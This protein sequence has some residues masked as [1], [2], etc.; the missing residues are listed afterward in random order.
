MQEQNTEFRGGQR[1]QLPTS[2]DVNSRLPLLTIA[3]P[4]WNREGFLKQNLEQLQ[5]ELATVDRDLVE[6]IVSDNCSPD[7]TQQVAQKFAQHGV[8]NRYV[9]NTANLG[10]ALNFAQCF[11]FA[12][13]RYLLLLGD[14]DLLFDGALSALLE[15]LRNGEFGVV[16]L[17]AY[18]FD[19]DFRLE[20]P[21][22]GGSAEEF[23]DANKF[24]LSVN[25]RFTLTSVCVINKSLIPNVDSKQF[26]DTNLATFHLVLRASLAAKRNL[27]LGAYMLACKRQ[28]SFSYDWAQVFVDEFWRIVDAHVVHG[29]TADCIRRI[30]Q[31]RLLSYY[32]FYAL[33][34]RLWRRSDPSKAERTFSKRFQ[35]RLL[36]KIWVA[37]IL[38]LPRVPAI[39]WGGM[40]T[41][42]GRV[43]GGDIARGY[44]FAR[45][46]VLRT[47]GLIR[48]P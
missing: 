12:R 34:L 21:G 19:S 30:E 6:I 37:P 41:L 1:D 44:A 4:T 43:L 13:G 14:D 17:R 46:R 2:S 11:D 23:L 31:E 7:G 9:R 10:W 35:G 45:H 20:H 39:L 42:V 29:L 5:S 24:L 40:A 47:L 25:R 48:R 15:L 28:N 27:K 16:C 38:T 8:V 33:D 26:A 22:Q 32:P 36:Y 3:I 18:G